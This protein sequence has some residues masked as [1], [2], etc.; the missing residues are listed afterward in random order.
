V[1]SIA[2]LLALG[3]DPNA[4]T[5]RGETPLHGAAAP[6]PDKTPDLIARVIRTLVAG[7]ALVNAQDS[8]GM[9]PL[10]RAALLGGVPALDALVAEGASVDLPSASGMTPLHVAAVFGH[11]EAVKA[12]LTA[13]ADPAKRDASGLTPLERALRSP[14]ASGTGPVDTREVEALLGAGSGPGR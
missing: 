5:V 3:A 10:H 7:H 2:V 11:A 4:R 12:L 6:Q 8:G 14:A 9:S 1:G 13:G